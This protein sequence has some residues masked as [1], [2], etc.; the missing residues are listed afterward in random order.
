MTLLKNLIRILYVPGMLIGYLLAA[1]LLVEGAESYLPLLV[2][3]F[4]AIALSFLAERW[5]PY[6][7]DWNNSKRDTLR[8]W[9]HFTVNEV[10]TSLNILTFPLVASIMPSFGVWPDSLPLW[11]EMLLAI[12]IADIGITLVHYWS[13]ISP[14]LWKFHAP[15]HSVKRMYGFNGL[16]KHPLHQL[17]ETLGGVLPLILLGISQDVAALLGFAVGL[18]LLLQHSNVD[19]KIGP[20]R[21]VLA[22]S[23]VHRFHHIKWGGEGDVNFGLFT[24]FTDRLLGTAFFDGGRK[25]TS[26]DLG[27][28]KEPDY[29]VSYTG[30][31]VEPF[32][33]KA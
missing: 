31:L 12:F 24:N 22:V 5:L 32:R 7:R 16:M 15:H 13:H 18:Q 23:P 8:D 25:F 11:C 10:S 3:L 2:L 14:W 28:G 9:I 17:M 19:V 26:D 30:Q 29:P 4:S 33:H 21:Y 6:N 20:L 1:V 27:I